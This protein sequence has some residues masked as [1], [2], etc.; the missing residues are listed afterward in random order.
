MSQAVVPNTG[1]LAGG[2]VLLVALW[3]AVY[4]WWEPAEPP[5]R[6]AEDEPVRVE[7]SPQESKPAVKASTDAAVNV[8]SEPKVPKSS[9]VVEPGPRAVRAPEF[10]EYVVQDG[11][12]FERIAKKIYGSSKSAGL[13]SRANPFVDPTK[14]RAGRKLRLPKDP[15][16]ITGKP[17][18]VPAAAAEGSRLYVVEAGDT[19]GEISRKLYG[20]GSMQKA[21]FE[22]NR[23]KLASPDSLKPGQELVVPP[24][25]KE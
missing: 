13:I 24:A 25:P 20:S 1:R 16:N 3:I 5:I 6:F 17:V 15:G 18:D 10:T 21:L 14:L 8:V 11:D 2:F 22:A 19:L 23:D 4:W 9:G 7:P 12:T